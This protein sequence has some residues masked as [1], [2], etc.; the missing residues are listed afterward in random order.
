MVKIDLPYIDR[1]KDRYGNVRY[2][3]RRRLGKRTPLPHPSSPEFIAAY[4]AAAGKSQAHPKVAGVR[5][6]EALITSYFQSSE[7]TELK[8]STKSKYQGACQW[9]RERYGPLPVAGMR[10][11]DVLKI[12]QRKAKD[13][14]AAAN[15]MLKVLRVLVR[16][17]FDLE[18]L[19]IDP[20]AKV[21]KLKEGTYHTWTEAEIE[22]FEAHWTPGSRERLAFALALYTGQRRA[23]IAGMTWAD[24][25]RHSWTVRVVQEKTGTK[26]TIPV[27]PA[28]RALLAGMERQI[29]IVAR[30]DGARMTTES[31]GNA[32]AD[33]ID[34][35]GLPKRCVLH[36]LRKAAARRLAE[37]G[38]SAKEIAA[39]TG[40]KTLSEVERYTEAAAQ[41]GLAERAVLKLR[42]E[43]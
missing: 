22:Q 40:H 25:D 31:L 7:Y 4:E 11:K 28:L 42:R 41:E 27:H 9:L 14:A 19:E 29:A 1:V 16:H 18:W 8:P 17:A 23:D 2:Y 36:G 13:G 20:T 39:I 33:A 15:T 32:M 5:T 43:K 26:L 3:Y 35:A 12:R 10:R 38:C 37:A 30:P 24:V 21:K 6:I 34:A